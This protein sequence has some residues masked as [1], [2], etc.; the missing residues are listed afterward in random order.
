MNE[1]H[2][3]Y[4][5]SDEWREVVE[6]ELVP[7]CLEQAELGDHLLE[8]GPGPGLTTDA[9]RRAV[10]HVTAVEVDPSLAA[11]LAARLSGTN[12]RVVHADATDT[13]LPA[14]MF[15]SAACFTML[16]HVPTSEQQDQL[17]GEVCRVLRDGGVFIGIDSLDSERIRR[18]HVDDVFN[19]VDP[20]TLGDRLRA[21]GFAEVAIERRE[22]RVRFRATRSGA[23]AT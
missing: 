12:V 18:G 6:R 7:W 20:D 16:H 17:F 22:D 14:A 2:M 19:P 21:A 5:V 11:A 13:G 10:P 1:G 23:R 9:L 15:S 4:L 3:T 8:I